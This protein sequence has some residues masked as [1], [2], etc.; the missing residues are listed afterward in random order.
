[1]PI[2]VELPM[3]CGWPAILATTGPIPRL[4]LMLSSPRRSVRVSAN[5]AVKN[6]ARRPS[7]A[8]A[9]RSSSRLLTRERSYR[10]RSSIQVK[11]GRNPIPNDCDVTSSPLRNRS[12]NQCAKPTSNR[13]RLFETSVTCAATDG[14]G[15][16]SAAA[17]AEPPMSAT[18]ATTSVRMFPPVMARSG[19][20]SSRPPRPSTVAERV[21]WPSA[22]A[23]GPE[24]MAVVMDRP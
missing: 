18:E 5:S 2:P 22:R 17:T 19:V 9:K 7:H 10:N 15:S 24:V 12:G 6:S 3:A 23:H 1:M 13:M 16:G 14:G 21:A 11:P 4:T 20:V 8:A